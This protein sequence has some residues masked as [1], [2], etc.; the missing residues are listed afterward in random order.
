MELYQRNA[1][2]MRVCRSDRDRLGGPPCVSRLSLSVA[3]NRG[4]RCVFR[5]TP[6]WANS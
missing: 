5:A 3:W 6:N 1:R 4:A 2:K